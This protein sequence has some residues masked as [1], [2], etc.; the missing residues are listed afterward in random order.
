MKIVKII[1]FLVVIAIVGS[2]IY[3]SFIYENGWYQT[4]RR[5]TA[6]R[7]RIQA[8]KHAEQRARLPK[9][10]DRVILNGVKVSVIKEYHWTNKFKVR[11]SNGIMADVASI[12]ML[13]LEKVKNP[14][15]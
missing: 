13:D 12:E 8:V 7:E 10:G 3:C 11:Y 1:I 9:A 6:E 5:E 14:D 2:F 15:K 4:F